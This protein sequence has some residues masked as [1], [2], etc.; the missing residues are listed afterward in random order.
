MMDVFV[1]RYREEA[2]SNLDPHVDDLHAYGELILD[3]SLETEGALTFLHP[4]DADEQTRDA[5]CVRVALPPRSLALIFGRA[6]IEWS[7]AILPHDTHGQRT[8][9]TIRTLSSAVRQSAEGARVAQ[10]IAERARR[11]PAPGFDHR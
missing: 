10:R 8:S 4:A 9:I 1:L 6:R 5:R 7:H 3:L 2:L 11:S